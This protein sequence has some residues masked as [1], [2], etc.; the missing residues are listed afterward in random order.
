MPLCPKQT[1]TSGCFFSF[2]PMVPFFHIRTLDGVIICYMKVMGTMK[3]EQIIA[4]I[5]RS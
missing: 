4:L 1:L 5:G 3:H 2:Y